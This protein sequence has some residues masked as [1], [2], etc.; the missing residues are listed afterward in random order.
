MCVVISSL[1]VT[2]RTTWNLYYGARKHHS[3]HDT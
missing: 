1:W 3:P 2:Y